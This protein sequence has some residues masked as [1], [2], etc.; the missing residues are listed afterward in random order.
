MNDSQTEQID[1]L[2]EIL[3]SHDLLTPDSSNAITSLRATLSDDTSPD[4]GALSR[5]SNGVAQSV[6]GSFEKFDSGDP[7]QISIAI[8][9]IV[10]AASAFGGPQTQ[11]IVG[12]FCT[13]LSG[14]LGFMS[15][16]PQKTLEQELHDV[17]S[18]LLTDF[19]DEELLSLYQK[20]IKLMEVN[21]AQ[22]FSWANEPELQ[23]L[24]GIKDRLS[25]ES[26]ESDGIGFMERLWYFIEKDLYTNDSSRAASVSRLLFAYVKLAIAR[27]QEITL[28]LM[29]QARVGHLGLERSALKIHEAYR[30]DLVDRLYFLTHDELLKK[31]GNSKHG[32][33]PKVFSQFILRHTK[34]ELLSVNLLLNQIGYKRGIQGELVQIMNHKNEPLNY[35][36]DKDTH[37]V[38]FKK[39]FY[40]K[41]IYVISED[42]NRT[43]IFDKSD[44]TVV[45]LLDLEA[46]KLLW[47]TSHDNQ[48]VF[49]PTYREDVKHSYFVLEVLSTGQQAKI[50][51]KPRYPKLLSNDKLI[52]ISSGDHVTKYNDNGKPTHQ[53]LDSY[54]VEAVP[55][56]GSGDIPYAAKLYVSQFP[57]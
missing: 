54:K 22:L 47:L 21:I 37:G 13:L 45:K 11:M 25:A 51:L 12:P 52:V 4:Y 20:E 35:E 49:N 24:E 41:A 8:F 30:K 36:T 42:E 17:V 9:D 53:D 7:A 1:R 44:T 2:E 10:G 31:I 3:S 38:F 18:K 15:K 39:G 50:T 55:I 27:E 57:R 26:F 33:V 48:L 14:V 46:S 29:L 5:A 56:H 40:P 28:L 23:K 34:D 19:R 16:G 32:N 6:V 43:S